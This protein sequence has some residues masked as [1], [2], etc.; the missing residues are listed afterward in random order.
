MTKV[1]T[2]AKL[3]DSNIALYGSKDHKDAKLA[4]AKTEAAW[5]GCGKV[6]GL[7]IWRIEKFKVVHWPKDQ[8]GKFFDGDSY[9]ILNT[10]KS[11]ENP[12]KLL[13]NVHFWLGEKS[14]QDEMGTAAYKTVELDDL[15]GDLPVQYRE[16]QGSESA[17]FTSLFASLSILCGGID[18][19]FKQ[20][21][22][23][24]YKPRLLHCKGIKNVKVTQVDLKTSSL[25]DGDVFLLDAGLQLYQW[26]G[27]SAS[28]HEKRKAQELVEALKKERNGKPKS[29]VIDGLEDDDTFWKILGG[30]PD[31]IA[32]AT[33]DHDVKPPEKKLFM[34]SDSTGTL[35]Q[36]EVA[37]TKDTFKKSDLK[38]E[39]V[40]LVDVGD[41]VYAWI[42]KGASKD[43]R[44][45]GIKYG[46]EYLKSSGRPMSTPV[47]RV[48]DGNEP[49]AFKAHFK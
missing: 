28:I 47:S 13:Y 11:P 29:Q 18:S 14:S 9:I 40:F 30:K 4:A 19:G 49:A 8:Y 6:P 48:M 16:V 17:Q 31:K 41:T 20:V 35:K 46:T 36:T 43:E 12:D 38:S 33:S 22:P 27:K 5:E 7:Q 10:Y 44:A 32:P 2:G 45:N 42:G 24:E 25:N 34:L 23:E 39:D 15:L 1:G 3:E 21:K 26:N 37:T